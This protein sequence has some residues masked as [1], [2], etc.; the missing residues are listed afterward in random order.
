MTEGHIISNHFLG[1]ISIGALLINGENGKVLIVKDS[2]ND[3]YELPGGRLDKDE[4][5]E[6]NIS[7]EINE[8]LGLQL[9]NPKIDYLWSKQ[10][11]HVRDNVMILFIIM[12]VTIT[13][14]EAEKISRSDEV[15][16]FVWVDENDYKQY[17]Y[18]PGNQD[19]LEKYFSNR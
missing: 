11:L 9:I 13:K 19:A 15:S 2:K 10:V 5:L 17:L 8:E 18:F 16:D 7:R 6:E 1:K 4:S 3:K 12:S 14:Q